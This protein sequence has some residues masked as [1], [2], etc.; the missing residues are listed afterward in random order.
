MEFGAEFF[1]VVG[2][3]AKS[4]GLL[5]RYETGLFRGGPD[6]EHTSEVLGITLRTVDGKVEITWDGGSATV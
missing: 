4:R 2:P 5:S 3:I 1:L 6:G